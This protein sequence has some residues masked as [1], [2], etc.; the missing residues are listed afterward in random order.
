MKTRYDAE[1][2][3]K[4][5]GMPNAAI[6]A[7]A[8]AGPLARAMLNVIELSAIAEPR[9]RRE[10]SDETIA[11]CAGAENALTTPS[12]SANTITVTRADVVG[13]REH[14]ERR[15]Q[16]HGAALRD[17]QQPPPVEAVG[18]APD[19]GASTS[20]GMKV[21]EVQDAEQERR[22]RQAEEQQRRG[23][24][25][26]PG[27][28]RRER[29][30]DEVRA[31]VPLPDDAEGGARPGRR[32]E[33]GFRAAH[34]PKTARA[35]GRE[36]AGATS[37]RLSCTAEPRRRIQGTRLKVKTDA[38]AA[39]SARSPAASMNAQV[40]SSLAGSLASSEPIEA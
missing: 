33:L 13:E 36:A 29:V 25:L 32:G 5:H 38:P 10:T 35:G 21:A 22:A 19:H 2:M 8:S 34:G 6:A 18:G 37:G 31:E 9:S 30:A 39:R 17:E 12:S 11:C 3:K 15:A 20:T 1:L 40:I 27:P 7:A 26:E 24:V 23:E 4:A 16:H 14:A 28:A